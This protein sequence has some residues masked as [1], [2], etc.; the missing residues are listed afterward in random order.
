MS[1]FRKG[2]NTLLKCTN[3]RILNTVQFSKSLPQNPQA[4][5][6]IR[7]DELDWITAVLNTCGPRPQSKIQQYFPQFWAEYDALEWDLEQQIVQEG[8]CCSLAIKM[9]GPILSLFESW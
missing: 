7:Y 8:I 4:W 6:S 1:D 5:G 2:K 3:I 9:L